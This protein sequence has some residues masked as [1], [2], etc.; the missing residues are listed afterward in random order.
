MWVRE[1][2]VGDIVSGAWEGGGDVTK[3]LSRIATRLRT[4]STNT[5]GNFSKEMRE[6]QSKMSKLMK[7]EQMGDVI[8]KMRAVDSRIDELERREELYWRQRVGRLGLRKGDKNS[9]FFNMKAQQR[10]ER[11]NIEKIK[12]GAGNSFEDENQISELFTMFF[13]D[14]FTTGTS[15]ES[16]AITGMLDNVMVNLRQEERD[17]LKKMPIPMFDYPDVW[18]WH[19]TRNG[20]FSVKSAY[21]LELGKREAVV[22]SSNITVTNKK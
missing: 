7:E 9:R 17:A 14:L 19:H 8:E 5:F 15:V 13:E 4:W 21:F 6:C 16:E 1:G 10:R 18:V 20:E 12:D 22:S 11:N 2:P 3:K